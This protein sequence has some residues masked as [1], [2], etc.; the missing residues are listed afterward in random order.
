MKF[1]ESKRL[2]DLARTTGARLGDPAHADLEVTGINTADEAEP[3]DLVWAETKEAQAH[4]GE[5][6]ATAAIV[7][8]KAAIGELPALIHPLP[9]LVFGILLAE[10]IPV[11]IDAPET[12]EIHPEARIDPRAVIRGE[13][14]IG[15]R[16]RVLAGAVIG[17]GCVIGEDCVVGHNSVLHWG[18]RLGNRVVVHS[19]SVLGT[20]GFGYVQKPL[21]DDPTTWES[22]KVPHAGIVIVEDDVEIGSNVCVDRGLLQATVIGRGTKID[23]LVQIGHNCRIGAHNIIIGQVGFSGSI[24]TGKN[25]I[26]AGQAGIADHT[27]IGDRA[28][29]MAGVKIAGEV[30]ADSKVVGYPPLAR[31]DFW[32]YTSSMM[33]VTLVKKILK[34]ATDAETYEEF[35]KVVSALKSPPGWF[36]K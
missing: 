27:H 25:V 23:N 3:G 7:P 22:L 21:G 1:N 11:E 12:C 26:A 4:L 36:K 34:A 14:R 8:P 30:P 13:V 5:R 2:G 9:K 32:R 10:F 19:C 33:D 18:T 28:V 24:T 16:S 31:Q 15:A 29:L 17:Q 35:K 20:D 6:G